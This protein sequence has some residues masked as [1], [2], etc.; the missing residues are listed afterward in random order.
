MDDGKRLQA[1]E[2]LTLKIGHSVGLSDVLGDRSPIRGWDLGSG[3]A[4][5]LPLIRPQLDKRKRLQ[6]LDN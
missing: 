3:V 5:R 4:K 1:L 6:A 2:V